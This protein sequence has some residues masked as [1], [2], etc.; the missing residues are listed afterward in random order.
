MHKTGKRSGVAHDQ[1]ERSAVASPQADSCQLKTDPER[2][3]EEPRKCKPKLQTG[4]SN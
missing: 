1:R 4:W 3:R 2:T